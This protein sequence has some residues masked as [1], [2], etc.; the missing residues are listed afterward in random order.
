MLPLLTHFNKP[1]LLHLFSHC[2]SCILLLAFVS[3][4]R[5]SSTLLS[6]TTQSTT[7]GWSTARMRWLLSAR[8]LSGSTSTLTS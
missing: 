4:S 7:A 6:R 1:S 2:Q 5:S 8:C 3:I